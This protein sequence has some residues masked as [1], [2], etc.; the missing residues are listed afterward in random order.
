MMS[1]DTWVGN[2]AGFAGWLF[3]RVGNALAVARKLSVASALALLASASVF[4]DYDHQY[5]AA[6]WATASKTITPFDAPLPT[7]NDTT[8]RQVVR[9]S[10]GGDGFRVWLTNEF[11]TA[12]LNIGEAHLALRDMD[13]AIV[14]GSDRM[15]TFGG[16]PTIAIAPGA[17]VVSDPVNLAAPHQAELVIS[18][19]LPDD[20][21][22]SESPVTYHVRAL[23]TNYLAAGN[24]TGAE[25][26]E[27]ASTVPSWFF[28]SGVDVRWY[29]PVAV[30][31][32]FGDSITDGDQ[33][34]PEPVDQNARY[35]DFLAERILLTHKGDWRGADQAT[36]VNL[37]ISGNQITSSFLGEN[38]QARLNRDVFTQTGVTH[39]IVLEG[40]ND[41]GLPV[42]LGA[43]AGASAAQLIAAHQ[44]IAA[45]ARAAGLKTIG[46]TLTPSAGSALPGYGMGAVE[47]ARQGLNEW[48]RTS[49]A[50]DMVADLDAV[51][52]DPDDPTRM[53][54]HL[55]ADGL[56]P[57]ADGY[58]AIAEEIHAV[59]AS[60]Y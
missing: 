5:W 52:R 44:Q 18:L 36:V 6:T 49:G 54:S 2:C 60:E 26:L 1:I 23:Q 53:L 38:A 45:R 56:H 59:L 28:I 55:T 13:S 32:A 58:R 20:L 24:Q 25:D 4:A 12:P 34:Q 27:A 22:S 48:I 14:P 31:A 21:S 15:L 16:Q 47:E 35:T 3:G 40:I 41:I 37:G 8:V 10:M 29:K 7:I 46:A 19:H 50:Y 17:R 30:I 43:P 39:V 51:L 11:G 9:I 42:L 33:T 57:N